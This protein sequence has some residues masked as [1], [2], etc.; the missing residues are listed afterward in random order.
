M[1][2]II[3]LFPLYLLAMYGS[4]VSDCCYSWCVF[5]L[6]MQNSV[7][8]RKYKK[9]NNCFIRPW[10]RKIVYFYGSVRNL[11]LW[12]A[13]YT[14]L[15]KAITWVSL[16]INRE[17]YVDK[18]NNVHLIADLLL[19]IWIWCILQTFSVRIICLIWKL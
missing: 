4:C 10:N 17:I 14:I 2:I 3:C 19:P 12:S 13:D 9:C 1:F 15:N 8:L 16:Y 18:K 5:F 6:S 7:S 11:M